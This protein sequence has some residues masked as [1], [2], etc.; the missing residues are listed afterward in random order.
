MLVSVTQE[1]TLLGRETG[2]PALER[3]GGFSLL[4][5]GV[6]FLVVRCRR[7]IYEQ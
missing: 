4:F 6:D 3:E 5:G 1:V 2:K 7:C